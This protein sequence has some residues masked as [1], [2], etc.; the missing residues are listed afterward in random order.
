MNSKKLL[1]KL[2]VT[3]WQTE[4]R[5]RSYVPCI[6]NN[7]KINTRFPRH[8][9]LLPLVEERTSSCHMLSFSIHFFTSSPYPCTLFVVLFRWGG[10]WTRKFQFVHVLN[11]GWRGGRSKHGIHGESELTPYNLLHWLLQSKSQDLYFT[12]RFTKASS[13]ALARSLNLATHNLSPI[14]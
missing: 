3:F 11:D 7:N 13:D 12:R 9:L 4:S 14:T 10:L 1:K 8:G 2:T 6:P 5:N